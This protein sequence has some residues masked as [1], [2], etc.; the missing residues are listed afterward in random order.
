MLDMKH[1]CKW[2]K[3]IMNMH[4]TYALYVSVFVQWML[5]FFKVNASY[6][7]TPKRTLMLFLFK[8]LMQIK[9]IFS[10][11]LSDRHYETAI[12]VL[13]WKFLSYNSKYS[14]FNL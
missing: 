14:F 2:Q 10:S 1:F 6:F 13:D 11:L 7:S 12:V 3:Q 4:D 5:G 9:Y 8:N